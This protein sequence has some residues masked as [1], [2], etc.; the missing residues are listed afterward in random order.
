MHAV[1]TTTAAARWVAQTQASASPLETNCAA[2]Q[3]TGLKLGCASLHKANWTAAQCVG[4]KLGSAF[5]SMSRKLGSTYVKPWK[6]DAPTA[7]DAGGVPQGESTAGW[8]VHSLSKFSTEWLP[9]TLGLNV[10]SIS[11]RS[12]FAQSIARKNAWRLISSAPSGPQPRRLFASRHS[13]PLSSDSACADRNFGNLGLAAL[14]WSCS[15]LRDLLRN[16]GT[17]HSISYSRMPVLHQSTPIEWP[18]PSMISGAMYSIVP[19]KLLERSSGSS[20]MSFASPK[21]VRRTW[22][23]WSSSTF[24]GFKSLCMMPLECRYDSADTISAAYSRACGSSKTPSRYKLKK[25]WPPLRKSSTRYSLEGVWNEKR[26]A[27]M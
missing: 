25:R 24:S 23:C 11:R 3:C 8:S 2:A 14:I 1:S 17:P 12:S 10:L 26:I 15:S 5:M 27:T 13:S 4:L 16:G 20:C 6:S 21:S 9:T 22:P 18:E 19:M 7:S